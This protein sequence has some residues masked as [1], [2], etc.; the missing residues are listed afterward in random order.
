MKEL[1]SYQD[2]KSFTASGSKLVMFSAT[3][4]GPCKM[5]KP[6]IDTKSQEWKGKYPSLEVAFVYE[7]SE[8]MKP[9]IQ[10]E[11]RVSAY[12]SFVAFHEGQPFDMVRGG[13]VAAIED[14]LS[15]LP[16]SFATEGHSLGGGSAPL[17]AAAAREARLAKL[18]SKPDV[19]VCPP[20]QK[21]AP[22]TNAEALKSLTEEMGFPEDLSRRGLL[23]GGGTLEGAIDWITLHQDD[24]ETGSGAMV[25]DGD[26]GDVKDEAG[27]V[28]SYKCNECGKI[29][30]NMANLELHAN[31]TGH[32]D[33]SESTEEVK[34][35]TP[36]EKAAK[37]LEIKALL[38]AKRKE[39]E[40]A[41]KVDHVA[42]EKQRREMGKQ[43]GKTREQMERDEL[44]RSANKKKKE[45]ID[46]K[47]ER[48]RIRAELLKDKLERKANK[49]KLKSKLG[50]DGYI[51]DAI[52]YDV[53]SGE[54]PPAAPTGMQ[55]DEK[56]KEEAKPMVVEKI[57]AIPKKQKSVDTRPGDVQ[58]KD[59]ITKISQYKVAE[60]GGNALKL[61]AVMVGNVV[62]NPEE[63]KYRGINTEGKAF[64]GKIKGIIGAKKVLELCGWEADGERLVLGDD[65]DW[66][67][68]GSAREELVKAR[69]AYF[70]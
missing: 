62:D 35:L 16:M 33:F 63:V 4:C 30:S 59:C 24:D 28:M 11:F 3:W 36:E 10:G 37:V 20:A 47:K 17:D 15:K 44:K 14:M 39:R 46:A 34:P 27:N 8:G 9:A 60:A 66:A 12:P 45:K 42:R 32:S 31:K 13:N 53:K 7:S 52:Q 26:S 69:D 40:E 51:P 67:F 29:M 41:E 56:P 48:E 6:V 57:S 21:S 5:I 49:G 18:G 2:L 64:K 65:V 68:I 50:V 61:L 1:T 19:P 38:K 58:L 25:L 55:I 54:T 23:H 70:G 22:E 43:M